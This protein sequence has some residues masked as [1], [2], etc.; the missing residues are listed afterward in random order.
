MG[1]F[2]TSA[3]RA[4]SGSVYFSPTPPTMIGGRGCL[5]RPGLDR[6][7]VDGEMLS[8]EIDYLV[9]EGLMQDLQRLAQPCERSPNVPQSSPVRSC[10][11]SIEPLPMPS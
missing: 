8:G 10:S 11:S 1:T 6:H 7:V 5:D 3:Y 2:Q 4:T 9:G